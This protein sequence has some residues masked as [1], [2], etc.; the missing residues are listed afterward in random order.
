ML[1]VAAAAAAAAT[2][3]QQPIANHRRRRLCARAF[4][5]ALAHPP[6]FFTYNA[7]QQQK[8]SNKLTGS[9]PAAA[10][11]ALPEMYAF[12][13]AS[14]LLTGS[15]PADAFFAQ[16]KL[17]ILDLSNNS[18]TGPVPLELINMHEL[19][20]RRV[21]FVV[22]CCCFAVLSVGLLVCVHGAVIS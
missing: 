9:L 5:R 1:V 13:A 11:A 12:T 8:N 6:P 3:V 17:A 20:V 21:C 2:R 22:C 19:D 16:T 15:I 14:N 18:L 10:I 7:T 4:P